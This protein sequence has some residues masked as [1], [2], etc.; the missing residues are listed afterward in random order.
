MISTRAFAL[1]LYLLFADPEIS[2]R[3][4]SKVFKE[5]RD[6]MATA[7]KELREAGLLETKK[8]HVNGRI[9]TISHVVEP[10][11][12]TAETAV[13]LQHTPLYSLLSTNSLYSKKQER[14][15]DEIRNIN[16]FVNTKEKRDTPEGKQ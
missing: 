13:L 12:W 1:Y 14:V 15:A 6:A 10:D 4:L 2:A 11:Y 7:L 5:G 9:M 3:R 16:S 8:V